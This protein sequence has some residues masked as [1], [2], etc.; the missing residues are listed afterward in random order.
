MSDEFIANWDADD[1]SLA[2]R[3]DYGVDGKTVLVTYRGIDATGSPLLVV[4][5][6]DGTKLRA[7]I[8]GY[9]TTDMKVCVV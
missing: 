8:D 9:C 3:K 5:F 6:T 2:I 1:G 7:T 4:E